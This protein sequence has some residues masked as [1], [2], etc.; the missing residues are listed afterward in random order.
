MSEIGNS[1][2]ITRA[3]LDRLLIETRYM[4]SETPD[5][6]FRLF[7]ET[8]PSPIMTAAL[9]HLDHFMFPGAAEAFA[10]GA[11]EAG[12]VCWY[13]MAPEEEMDA[14]A[15]TGA[16]L[17][18][19]IKPYT[20]REV[21]FRKIAHA[22]EKGF[23]AVGVDIDH[24]FGEGGAKDVVSGE[25]MTPL[26]TAELEEICRTSRLPVIVKGVLSLKD[27]EKSVG[28]GADALVLSHHNNRIEYA[29]PPAAVLPEIAAAVRGQALLFADC[30]VHTG[31]DAFKLLALGADGVCIGR[32]LMTAIRENGAAG[33]RDYLLRANRELG[34]AMAFTGCTSLRKMDPTVIRRFR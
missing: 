21:I 26:R 6:T 10:Q 24:A 14:L 18:E 19:I 8:F 32:P 29:V 1:N 11:R 30:E 27:A 2:R 28:A 22:E 9:S 4:D 23:L 16:R 15:A 17:I 31:M 3:Y 12:A 13:G 34:K 25:E 5:L 33:V 20:D 7:G